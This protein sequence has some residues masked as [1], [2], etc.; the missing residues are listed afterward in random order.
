MIKK[1]NSIIFNFIW[2]NKTHYLK[3]SVMVKDYKHG[4]LKAAD[5]ES[6]IGVLKLNWV[7]AYLTQSNSIWFHIPKYI[8]QNV[9]GLEF[10]LRCDFE[11]TKLPIKLSDFHKQ[12]LLYWKMMFTHNFTPHSSTLWNNRTILI[13]RKTLFKQEWYDKNVL[14]V[15]DLM[16]KNGS[17]L[18]FNSFVDKFNLKCSYREFNQISRAIPLPLKFMIKNILTNS[19]VTVKLPELKIGELK[20]GEGKCNNKILGSVFKEKLFYDIKKPTKIKITDNQ[21]TLTKTSC[22]YLKWPIS[23][24][25][26]EIQ[27]KLINNIYPAAETLRKRLNFEVNP[28]VFCM[29]EHETIEHLF[30]LLF[31]HNGVLEGCLSMVKHWDQ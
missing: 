27:F 26:K 12:I 10:L 30:F 13:N 4:G 28:C 7:K 31:S 18:Q 11:I 17:L 22:S 15:M 5:F 9:G 2:K 1:V 24:K 20:F 6:M 3:K 14:Y 21:V 8:F 23:P 29:T 16:D 19:N 25:V